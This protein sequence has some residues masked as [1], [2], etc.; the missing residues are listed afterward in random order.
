MSS[1]SESS[2]SGPS[3]PVPSPS[4]SSPSGAPPGP[5]NAPDA[6]PGPV[7]S[8]EPAEDAS[9]AAPEDARPFVVPC[10]ALDAGA[11]LR[12]LRAGWRDL[13]AAPGLSLLFGVVIVLVSAGISL[14]AWKLGRFA[15]LATLLSGFVFVAP[16]ICVGLYCVSRALARGETP[17]LAD[18][19]VL[20]RRVV[21]QAGVFAIAQGVIVL[22][23]SRAGMMVGAF[24][25]ID[26]SNV[27]TLWE[28]LA[29]G[30]A[31]GSIFAALTFAVS[32][33][34]LPMIAD[35][36]VDMITAGIS[37]INAVLR[38]KRVMLLWATIIV[39]LTAIGFATALI[40]LG[41]LMPWLAYAAWHGYRETLDASAWPRLD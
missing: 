3:S 39:V 15:L 38:N 6:G 22:L 27:G 20:A 23:W 14:L 40:G 13:R 2:P 9:A 37:S 33:F 24:F 34:S 36:D 25:P 11:P 28:F 17:R 1:Q 7:S 21:G 19:F 41:L 32:A 5:N 31:V 30:S 29:I 26:E 12:W 8:P 35:R 16:L 10:A 4:M 18:S